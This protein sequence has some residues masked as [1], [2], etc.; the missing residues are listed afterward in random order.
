MGRFTV[1]FDAAGRFKDFVTT[2]PILLGGSVSSS[3]IPEKAS[4]AQ[5]IASLSGPVD[6][7]K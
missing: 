7:L 3:N 4:V 5:L 2:Q 6:A 1:T